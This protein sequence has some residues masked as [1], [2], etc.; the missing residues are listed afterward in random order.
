[1]IRSKKHQAAAVLLVLG[2]PIGV[3]QADEVA[4]PTVSVT[5]QAE[6][7]SI[8]VDQLSSPKFSQPLVDT[9]QTVTV[10]DK[11]LMQQQGANTLTEALRNTPGV[12]TFFLGENGN[13]TTGD[14]VYMR[15]YDASSSIYVDGVQ[16]LGAIS[17]DMFNVDQV[18]VIK[19]A[20]STDYGVSS[21]AGSINLVTK[22]ANL[23][24][25]RA[26][27]LEL[28][29]SYT[30]ATADVNRTLSGVKG[31]AVRINVMGQKADV[32]GR[33]SLENNRGGVAASVALGLGTA[34][35]LWFDA[36]YL[37]QN[38]VPD[39]GVPT[40]GLPGYTSPDPKRPFLGN[41]PAV[42]PSNFYGTDSDYQKVTSSRYT[43]T[44]EHDFNP[45]T[46]LRNVTRWAQTQNDYLLTSFMGSAANWLTPN[47]SDYSTWTIARSTP[48]FLNQQNTILTN[49][50]SL[51]TQLQTG[52][53]KHDVLVGVELT[54][55][56]QNNLSY[57]TQGAWP[58]ANLYA[59]NPN[60]TG[61]T[62]YLNGG[63]AEGTANTVAVYAFD[64]AHLTD[65]W[66]LTGG[67]RL[68][69]YNTSFNSIQAC[70]TGRGA[71]ACTGGAAIGTL[72]S[73]ADLSTSGNALSLK[74]G[75]VYKL[76]PD[77]SL[78]VNYANAQMPP[79][80]ANFQLSTSARAANNPNY[81]PQKTKTVEAG[82]KWDA[83]DGR[84][85]L[86][87]AVYR[88]EVLNGIVQDPVSLQYYQTGKQRVQGLELSAVGNITPEWQVNAGWSL[89]DTRVTSG[90]S[91]GN[92]PN[93]YQLN[94]TPRTAFT[95]W[96]SYRVTPKLTLAG[97]PRYTSMLQRG[98]D[99]AVGTPQYADSYWVVDAMASYQV[100]KEFSLQLNVYN[101][102][103][104]E[105][106]AAINKSGY[107]YTPGMPRTVRLT[108]A[109]KF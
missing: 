43:L 93:D 101:L 12:S 45:N 61:L 109:V 92:D 97:G 36:M 53:V 38:N 40:I 87:A 82:A 47:P 84:L 24:D 63:H 70:G 51:K 37:K 54:Q 1:M 67:V 42:D 33:D 9:P 69:H 95:S 105:Y 77:S 23:Q 98:K 20:A 107:R 3:S 13:T 102:F 5:G 11:A 10:I 103:D 30:R 26:G 57:A 14:A 50:T 89:M 94:Y 81:D 19:G 64:T 66:L 46:T 15:G 31:G 62:W 100:T 71:P 28:G 29:S 58:A 91:V 34:N 22:Q 8:K 7:E 44:L 55:S 90:Q 76:T 18:E 108:A 2:A 106:V 6:S 49:Q 35:R 74:L 79:G 72:V 68:D 65:R 73:A 32:P 85:G 27:S 21:P 4:L 16:D 80:S 52:A 56:K 39:G 86:A 48:T 83:L 75:T 104:K 99:G 17:R 88:T 60:V 96:T 41:A 78:Y 25:S 59:P